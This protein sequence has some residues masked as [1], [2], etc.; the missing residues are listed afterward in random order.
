MLGVKQTDR[1]ISDFFQNININSDCVEDAGGAESM[2]VNQ[3]FK[4]FKI[5][6]MS[7]QT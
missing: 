7:I 3:V 4:W 6:V 1:H 2:E 5:C